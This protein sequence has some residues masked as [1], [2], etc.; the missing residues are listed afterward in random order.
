MTKK[1]F[2]SLKRLNIHPR[3]ERFVT[4]TDTDSR[5]SNVPSVHTSV[6]E[7]M[8]QY[9]NSCFCREHRSWWRWAGWLLSDDDVPCCSLSLFFSSSPNA[10]SWT[11][12][13]NQTTI[14]AAFSDIT[15]VWGPSAFQ[16]AENQSE[17]WE[18][19][20]VRRKVR[21]LRLTSEYFKRR[22][23]FNKISN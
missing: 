1:F 11:T 20:I 17:F 7:L 14:T 3:V 2:C 13:T 23:N 4:F 16:N 22:Q 12:Q 15:G 21:V 19:Q 18:K 8:W 6:T 10:W 5:P 9:A